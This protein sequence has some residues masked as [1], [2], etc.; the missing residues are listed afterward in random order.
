MWHF[1][2]KVSH[3]W[4]GSMD[5]NSPYPS[6]FRALNM[7]PETIVGQLRQDY[8]EEEIQDND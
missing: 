2:R 7:A 6:V 8:T 3:E 4:I 1:Q 5:L